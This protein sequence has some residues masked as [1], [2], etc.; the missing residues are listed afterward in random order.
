MHPEALFIIE[1]DTALELVKQHIQDCKRVTEQRQF[2]L[3]E[4][5]VTHCFTNIRTGVVTG[6]VFDKTVHPEFCKPLISNKVSYPRKGSSWHKR[7]KEQVGVPDPAH[8]ISKEF[9]IPLSLHYKLES[10]E[11][12]LRLGEP[13]TECGF[14]YIGEN[15]PYAMW[16]PDV[17]KEVKQQES[18]GS[19]VQEPAKSFK[20]EFEGCRRIEPED[21][22]ILVL[23]DK[24]SKKRPSF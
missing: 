15:G 18:N 7:L 9:N 16:V 4:L 13:L 6:V 8:L 5:G 20:L 22:E 17:N 21:W 23:L 1:S 11:G 19:V 12:V 2:L 14:L 10:S 3:T 24:L